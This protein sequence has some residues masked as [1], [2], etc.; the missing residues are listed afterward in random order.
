MDIH[1][2]QAKELLRAW[3]RAGWAVPVIVISA[4]PGEDGKVRLL[5][6]GDGAVTLEFGTEISP[7]L[8]AAILAWMRCSRAWMSLTKLS[9]RSATNFTGRCSRIDSATVAK[10]S[11]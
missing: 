8:V 4:R 6:A 9:S 10:S 3:R 1:E 5:D 2:Y 7:A 11:G